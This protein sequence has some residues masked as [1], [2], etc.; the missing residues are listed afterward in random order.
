MCVSFTLMCS[1]RIVSV[2][3]LDTIGGKRASRGSDDSR[4][5]VCCHFDM[6]SC[7]LLLFLSFVEKLRL[8]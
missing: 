7:L 8:R 4:P 2:T 3:I 5:C 1:C 6:F